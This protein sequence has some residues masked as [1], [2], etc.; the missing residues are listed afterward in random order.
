MKKGDSTAVDKIQGMVIERLPFDSGED[1]ICEK[2]KE[3]K[4]GNQGSL[5]FIRKKLPKK[6]KGPTKAPKIVS[7]ITIRAIFDLL[8]W[9]MEIP[10]FFSKDQNFK[11][12]E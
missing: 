11:N 10:L 4:E 6:F 2:F 7:K 8:R 1:K 12:G 9:S 3:W 5:G